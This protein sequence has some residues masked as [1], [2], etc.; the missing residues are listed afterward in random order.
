MKVLIA[1]GLYPPEIGGPA[2]HVRVLEEHLKPPQFELVT[3]TY[4]RVRHFPQGLRGIM[5]LWY[6][7]R[8]GRGARVVYALDPVGVGLPALFASWILR[9]P[10]V[11]RLGGDY[12]WEVAQQ[13]Y[14]RSEPLSVFN[15]HVDTYPFWVRVLSFAQR[16]VARRA[17]RILVPSEHMGKLLLGWGIEK[18]RLAVLYS[19]FEPRN[20]DASREEIRKM[21]SYDGLVLFSAGRL[22]PWKGFQLLIEMIPELNERLE[23]KVT[24][25]IAGDGPEKPA[26]EAR[27]TE[28]GLEHSVRLIGN[29]PQDT[30]LTAVKGADMFVHNAGYS[31]FAHQLLE[32]MHL[33]VPIVTTEVGVNPELITPGVEGV[34]VPY[35]DRKAFVDAIAKLAA[36][37]EERTRMAHAAHERVKAYTVAHM[38]EA[39]TPVFLR[40]APTDDE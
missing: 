23:Q 39:L 37:P 34:L 2:T 13:R 11:L 15:A 30:L 24:L 3:V 26:L 6:L 29:Q 33:D 16:F 35:N 4:G 27:V 28:L 18:D 25:I 20:I 5:Y 19:I 36:H 32:V 31:G 38:I 21:F 7:I 40:Y 14:G 9:V 1:T 22:V 10:L 12:A 8:E 17:E